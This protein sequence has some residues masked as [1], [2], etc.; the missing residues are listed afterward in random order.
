MSGK[1][2]T[3]QAGLIILSI[4]GVAISGYLLYHHSHVTSGYQLGPSFC[5]FGPKFDCDKVALSDYSELFGHPVAAFGLVYYIGLLVFFTL[6]TRRSG[7]SAE[8]F[9]AVSIFTTM[10]S[11]PPSLFLAYVS[12]AE[13]GVLCAFCSLLYFVNIVL[14]WISAKIPEREKPFWDSFLS[15]L[16]L[17]FGYFFSF[18]PAG[19][20]GAELRRSKIFSWLLLVLVCLVSF[21]AK[22]YLNEHYFKPRAEILFNH[23]IPKVVDAWKKQDAA[24]LRV[25]A[26]ADALSKEFIKGPKDA[27][28]TIIEFSDFRCPFCKRAAAILQEVA[29]SRSLEPRIVFKNYPLDSAC[30]RLIEENLHENA[31]AAAI[32]AR[33]AGAQDELMFWEM[34][35]LLFEANLAD[36]DFNQLAAD[37]GLDETKFRT[38]LGSEE[39][40]SKV[41]QD[42]EQGIAVKLRGTPG[43]FVQGKPLILPLSHSEL[44]MKILN[45]VLDA[46]EQS[47]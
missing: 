39:H 4:M 30:N 26:A 8:N 37:L 14:F 45:A 25:V 31:C 38:C 3:K 27:P 43:I 34:H 17:T 41:K 13:I 11:L 23:L 10:L 2:F 6:T 46:A 47:L 16:R 22:G 15:G 28:I 19:D 35:D 29:A 18:P 42:I 21:G 1:Y 36:P 32:A 5:S 40:M 44:S 7:I 24:D 20:T 9:A 12:A 33:C